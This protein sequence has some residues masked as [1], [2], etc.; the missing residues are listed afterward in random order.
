MSRVKPITHNLLVLLRQRMPNSCFHNRL[1]YPGLPARILISHQLTLLSWIAPISHN[2]A[3]HARLLHQ[4]CSKIC[5][6]PVAAEVHQTCPHVLGCTCARDAHVLGCT[7]AGVHQ[8]VIE[9]QTLQWHPPA[10]KGGQRT[11]KPE[12]NFRKSIDL[13]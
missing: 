13:F 1:T 10:G 6:R 7:C 2:G 11:P 5:T 9:H 3:R 4:T 12:N 8:T